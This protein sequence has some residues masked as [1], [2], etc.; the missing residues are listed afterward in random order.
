MKEAVVEKLAKGLEELELVE[1]LVEDQQSR[2]HPVG[3][4]QVGVEEPAR[5]QEERECQPAA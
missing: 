3:C 1:A 2:Q 4:V 5:S